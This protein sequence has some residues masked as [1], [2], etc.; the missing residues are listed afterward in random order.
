MVR[1]TMKVDTKESAVVVAQFVEQSL[2]TQEIRGLNP[3]ISKFNL[4]STV[5]KLRPEMTHLKR[6][7][8]GSYY[9]HHLHMVIK[10]PKT[11]IGQ[12]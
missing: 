9:T 5:L 7:T 1:S 3:V 6:D 4:P 8:K 11:K 10:K 2:P 12:R